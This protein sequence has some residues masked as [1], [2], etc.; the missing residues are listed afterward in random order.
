MG[1]KTQGIIDAGVEC[2]FSSLRSS[3]LIIPRELRDY[4]NPGREAILGEAKTS[5]QRRTWVTLGFLYLSARWINM[6]DPCFWN[7]LLVL[8]CLPSTGYLILR[9]IPLPGISL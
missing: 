7:V 8:G 4:G 6:S 1:K 5:D 2:S 9:G 3:L